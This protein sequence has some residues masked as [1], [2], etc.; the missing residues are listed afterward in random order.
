MARA[1]AENAVAAGGIGALV[2][3]AIAMIVAIFTRN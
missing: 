3:L 2:L 1:I